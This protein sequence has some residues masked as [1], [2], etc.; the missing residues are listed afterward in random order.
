MWKQSSTD[1]IA[2]MIEYIDIGVNLTG[3][4]FKQD[5]D[6]V[7]KRAQQVGVSQMIV[8]GTDIVHSELAL[9]LNRQY[10]DV[11]MSTAGVHPHHASEFDAETIP[12]LR[13]LC[14]EASILAVGECGLD[15]NRNYSEPADQRRAFEAQLRLASELELPVFL[16][17]RD[18]NA[19]FVS[20]LTDYRDD[21]TGAVAHCF[22]GSVD[23][24]QAYIAMDMYIGITGWICDERRG[25]ELQQAVKQIP[26]E[27]IMLETDAPYLLPR[28]LQQPPIQKRRN[29]PCYLPHIC[30]VTARH[31]G[32]ESRQLAQAALDNSRRFFRL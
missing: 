13:G 18:A 25:V 29:E 14:G 2:Y 24:A 16:H 7:V 15:Y 9:Q 17:Q 1:I 20:M 10:P 8:T 6:D 28:D 3:S 4:S 23:Q 21:L 12:R 27:R 26:L 32:I 5:L 22:T 31:M 30:Q 19:D 11:L